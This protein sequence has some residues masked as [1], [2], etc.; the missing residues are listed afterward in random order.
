MHTTV[1]AFPPPRPANTNAP[2]LAKAAAT[3]V[4]LERWKRRA[5]PFR[6]PTGVFFRTSVLCTTGDIA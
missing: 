4:S 3:V 1:I 5:R 2:G 6:T